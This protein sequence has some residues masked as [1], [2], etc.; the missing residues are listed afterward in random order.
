MMKSST[1]ICVKVISSVPIILCY[2]RASKTV[3]QSLP[4]IGYIIFD[5]VFTNSN[6]ERKYEKKWSVMVIPYVF[7][8]TCTD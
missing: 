5:F 8:I 6:I 7:C 1:D 3:T 4:V 2:E